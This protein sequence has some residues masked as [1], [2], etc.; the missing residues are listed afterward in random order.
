MIYISRTMATR[1][2]TVLLDFGGV[3]GLPQDP[4]RIASM[5]SI[6]GLTREA[7]LSA[8]Q[9][10]RLELDRG[11]LSPDNYWARLMRMGG[12]TPTPDLI[13]RI[14]REDALG[15]TRINQPMVDW[16]AE[17]RAAGFRTAILSNMPPDKVTFLRTTEGFSWIDDF[18]VVCFS[19][20]Y[21]MVKP[22]PEFYRACLSKLSVT[23]SECVFLD[24]SEINAEAA[25]SLGID[26]VLYRSAREAGTEIRRT[27]GLPVA[28]L[29][30]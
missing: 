7:F 22:E 9:Q 24:D 26:A 15:W 12:V 29:M 23:P 17:L 18:D 28:S 30:G 6:C 13:V 8:Y 19:C 25:R 20:D 21:R 10:D 1:K 3:L 2:T 11:A 14:E 4:V 27:W 5:A 16:A